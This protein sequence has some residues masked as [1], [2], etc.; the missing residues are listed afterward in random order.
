MILDSYG[1]RY[2]CT[3]PF[4]GAQVW[5]FNRSD[6]HYFYTIKPFWVDDFVVKILTFYFNFWGS[7]ALVSDVQAKHTRKELMRTLSMRISSLRACSVHASVPD[8]YAQHGMKALLKFG[9]FTAYAEHTRQEL[10]G[11]LSMRFSSWCVCSAGASVPDPYAQGTHQSL[12]CML[13]M[14]WRECAP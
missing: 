2:S 3:F 7:Q 13:S 14:L 6:F 10:K 11:M 9:F 8:A 12:M 1:I 4:K 5:F